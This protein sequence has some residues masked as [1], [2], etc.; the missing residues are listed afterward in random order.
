MTVAKGLANTK[1]EVVVLT[2]VEFENIVR[3]DQ[4]R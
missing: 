1:I 3:A 2:S 4:L